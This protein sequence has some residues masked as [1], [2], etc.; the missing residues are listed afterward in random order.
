MVPC[1]FGLGKK[2]NLENE[3]HIFASNFIQNNGDRI[4]NRK[5]RRLSA[6]MSSLFEKRQK[7]RMITTRSL[8]WKL[9]ISFLLTQKGTFESGFPKKEPQ[10]ETCPSDTR[11]ARRFSTA[12]RWNTESK[13]ERDFWFSSRCLRRVCKIRFSVPFESSVFKVW[14]LL[15]RWADEFYQKQILKKTPGVLFLVFS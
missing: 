11:S 9:K 13:A 4:L 2:K 3:A 10:R 5:P 8:C 1:F 6:G 15:G 12:M 14:T 7:P